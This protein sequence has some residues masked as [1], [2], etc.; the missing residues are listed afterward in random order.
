MSGRHLARA[1]GDIRK[2]LR[3]DLFFLS[4]L[5]LIALG[6]AYALYFDGWLDGRPGHAR[7]TTAEVV[8]VVAAQ[9]GG[10][11]VVHF[12]Y[13]DRSGDPQAAT[14]EYDVPPALKPGDRIEFSYV[15]GYDDSARPVTDGDRLQ[16][17]ILGS[18]L[19]LVLV[20]F[21]GMLAFSLR[22][23]LKRRYLLVHGRREP[24]Q[25]AEIEV[26]QFAFKGQV[27][28]MWRLLMKR[29]DPGRAAWLEC[30][31]DWQPGEA[32]VLAPDTELPPI[33]VDPRDS[34]RHYL[35]TGELGPDNFWKA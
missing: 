31:S 28:P 23:F 3:R 26:M 33:L 6:L 29:F 7:T 32:P 15:V 20:C 4:P 10:D 22:R 12:V 2:R 24:G 25:G 18:L 5:V 35:P 17:R 27:Q 14:R 13:L 34:S 21:L 19:A 30:R 8:E 1:R 16:H 11:T 9:D